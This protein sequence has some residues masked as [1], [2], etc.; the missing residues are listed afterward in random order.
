MSTIQSQH[1]VGRPNTSPPHASTPQQS[2]QADER[3]NTLLKSGPNWSTS[4][5]LPNPAPPT[6]QATPQEDPS[7]LDPLLTKENIKK[8]I[9]TPNSPES[10]ALL[11]KIR[12]RLTPEKVQAM[13]QGPNGEANEQK[14]KALGK[15][16]DKAEVDTNLATT[17]NQM[18]EEKS[19]QL[20]R[21]NT[22]MLAKAVEGEGMG[23]NFSKI[24]QL[25]DEKPEMLKKLSESNKAAKDLNDIGT[26]LNE[27]SINK[28]RRAPGNTYSYSHMGESSLDAPS[29][30]R[31]FAASDKL[32]LSGIHKQLNK[33]LQVVNQ[34]TG[35][36]GEIKIDYSP[37]T[38]T[39]VV[40]VAAGPGQPHFVVKVFGEV[41]PDNLIT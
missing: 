18:I 6:Q 29:E 1:N 22:E 21:S 10:K 33:P 5:K 23:D 9:Q 35:A 19:R 26:S 4:P 3:V 12:A 34:F 25:E 36:S 16:L 15:H 30:I 2:P 17:N 7:D 27:D 14:L 8:I 38:N 28:M 24:K 11:E 20:S 39:S 41:R 32:D 37:S 31:N 40:S 13:L